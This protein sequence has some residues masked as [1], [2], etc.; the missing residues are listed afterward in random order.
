VCLPCQICKE[1]VLYDINKLFDFFHP[2]SIKRTG[3]RSVLHKKDSQ[4]RK[5]V[6][7]QSHGVSS[8][9]RCELTPAASIPCWGV[10]LLRSNPWTTFQGIGSKREESQKNEKNMNEYSQ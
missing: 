4:Q 2:R 1:R 6:W 7:H 10:L 5:K 3:R 8:C 9:I